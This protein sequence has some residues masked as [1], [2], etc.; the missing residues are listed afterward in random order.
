MAAEVVTE[1]NQKIIGSITNIPWVKVG[2]WILAFV[3]A[4]GGGFLLYNYYKN[5][6]VFNKE[7]TILEVVG[8]H[9]VPT[10]K[11]L[12]KVVKIGTGGFEI[13]YLKKLK[14]YKIAYGGRV[15]KNSYYFFIGPDGYW[16]NGMFSSDINYID[17]QGGLVPIVTTNPLMRAQYTSLE[18][19]VDILHSAKKTFMQEYGM[20][21]LGAGFITII[22]VF[23]WLIFRE[24]SPIMGA[25]SGTANTQAIITDKLT[26]LV[27]RLNEILLDRPITNYS[28]G[29]VPV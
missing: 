10:A 1:I 5:K 25:V 17:E 13:L 9:Y 29:L 28:G 2:G 18:K 15:G 4:I 26:I 20:W 21:V 8:V 23:A 12:M 16:Y 3:V 19:Q 7:A 11:D 14:I 27:E 24:M 22:G 6:K